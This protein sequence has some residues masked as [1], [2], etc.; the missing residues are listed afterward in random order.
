MGRD[1]WMLEQ[2]G[3]SLFRVCVPSDT[4]VTSVPQ[5]QY[6]SGLQFPHH[7]QPCT[8][9]QLDSL[10]LLCSLLRTGREH[11]GCT[12]PG[13]SSVFSSSSYFL[14]KRLKNPKRLTKPAFTF[15][16]KPRQRH[17]AS[18][19][20]LQTSLPHFLRLFWRKTSQS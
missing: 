6:S 2:A 15:V 10:R 5:S 14:T 11:K 9:F 13:S 16:G 8:A 3:H 12:S 4:C 18:S 17:L 19:G 7:P 1:L 20:K